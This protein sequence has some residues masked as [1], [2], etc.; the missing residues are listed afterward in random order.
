VILRNDEGERKATHE[1]S[2]TV[3]NSRA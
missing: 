3:R 1:R 2:F